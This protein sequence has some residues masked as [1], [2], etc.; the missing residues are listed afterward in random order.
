MRQVVRLPIS[1]ADPRREST[2]LDPTGRLLAAPPLAPERAKD[3]RVK[4]LAERIAAGQG[5]E[6]DAMQGWL[7]AQGLPPADEQAKE[8]SA[9]HDDA[10][11]MAPGADSIV[12]HDD[13]GNVRP[14]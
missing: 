13:A 7:K 6:I 2:G 10:G 9:G 3:E 1:H 14:Y 5:A 4:R 11:A 12:V 8:H